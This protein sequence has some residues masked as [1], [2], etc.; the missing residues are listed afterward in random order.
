M[1]AIALVRLIESVLL[2]LFLGIM[3]VA[4]LLLWH[5]WLP[6]WLWWVWLF[7]AACIVVG[8][9]QGLWADEE[10]CEDDRIS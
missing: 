6:S 3:F 8:F 9:V 5:G 7:Y 2:V 1:F 10:A 4:G